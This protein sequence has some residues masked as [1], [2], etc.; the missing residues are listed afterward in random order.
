MC[1]MLHRRTC[2]GTGFD[3]AL[4]RGEQGGV[5]GKG[6]VVALVQFCMLSDYVGAECNLAELSLS[7]VFLKDICGSSRCHHALSL[8]VHTPRIGR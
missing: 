8:D 4:L 5:C 6:V 7:I 1:T 3:V 2:C